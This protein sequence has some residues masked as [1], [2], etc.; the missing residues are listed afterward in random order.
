MR[1]LV[2]GSGGQLG[3]ELVRAAWPAGFDVHALPHAELDVSDPAQVARV[4]SDIAPGLVVNAAAYTDVDRAE[5]ERELAF[6][7][8]RDGVELLA[9]HAAGAGVVLVHV[10]TD[11]VFDGAKPGAYVE[12]DPVAPLGAYGASKAAGEERVRAALAAHVIVRTSWVFSAHGHNFVK[13]ML[14]LAAER[15]QLCVV[16]DQRGRPTPA[17]DL[18]RALVAVASQV[19]A[20]DRSHFGTY[21]YAGSPV[22]TWYAFAQSIFDLWASRGGRRPRLEAVSSNGYPTSAPRPQNS[23]LDCRRILE[24]FGVQER[25]W[26]PGLEAVLDELHKERP[27]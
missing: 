11:Y 24:A 18:A 8:N 25:S 2:T 4:L 19:A 12:S 20:G 1:V 14:G 7:V 16:D 5:K 15:E 6:A 22:T 3:R 17:A 13:T 26:R 9:Q 10:S 27:S 21:H 23:E